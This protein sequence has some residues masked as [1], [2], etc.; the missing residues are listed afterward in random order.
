MGQ[1]KSGSTILGVALGNCDGVFF[2]GELAS[3]LMTSGRPLLG[4]TERARFWRDVADDVPIPPELHGPSAFHHLER[5]NSALRLEQRSAAARIREL[6]RPLTGALYR[7]VA[8]RAGATHI[9]DTSHLPLRARELQGLGDIDLHLLFLVRD[10]E[11]IVASH[12]RH[13]KSREVAERRLRF[14]VINLHLWVTYLLSVIVFLRQPRDRRLLV[15]HEDFV[16]DPAAVMREILDFAGSTAAIPDLANLSTG[17]PFQGNALLRQEKVALKPNPAPPHQQSRL[18]R[19]LQ[20]P[21]VLVFSRLEP[22]AT[23]RREAQPRPV[24]SDASQTV[25]EAPRPS[26][27]VGDAS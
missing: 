15:R 14:L 20:R 3:W 13:V 1:G 4:G 6:Y 16:A 21:W 26:Q 8:S 12:T 18:I 22:T 27:A 11:S 25:E 19:L 2:A 17:L 7:S 23:G 10:A 5:G 24:P 9:I